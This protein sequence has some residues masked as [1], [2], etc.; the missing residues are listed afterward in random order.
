MTM[1]KWRALLWSAC[2]VLL[3]GC[4]FPP[5]LPPGYTG[6]TA[7]IVTTAGPQSSSSIDLFDLRRINGERMAPEPRTGQSWGY[8]NSVH[9]YGYRY[10]IPA[11]QTTVTIAGYRGYIM[12]LLAMTLG[13]KGAVGDVTFTPEAGRVYRVGGAISDTMTS[14]WVQDSATGSILGRVNMDADSRCHLSCP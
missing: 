3:A 8:G 6:P 12:P 5:S 13:S 9:W 1:V 14:V 4:G 7:V 2:A 10:P 11:R